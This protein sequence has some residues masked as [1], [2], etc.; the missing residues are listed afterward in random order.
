MPAQAIS[1]SVHNKG[2]PS[3]AEGRTISGRP[4]M[5]GLGQRASCC[6][7][8]RKRSPRR[9]AKAIAKLEAAVA[10]RSRLLRANARE[11]REPCGDGGGDRGM[12]KVEG[13]AEIVLW[14]ADMEAALQFYRDQFG[15]EVISPAA[16]PNKF[17][18]VAYSE[19]F[20]R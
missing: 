4:V 19:G 7:D 17:L 3:L 6:T 20:P 2:N 9:R 1:W 13:L 14:V 18:M 12:S 5:G 8:R 11:R 16:L 10:P 15:L